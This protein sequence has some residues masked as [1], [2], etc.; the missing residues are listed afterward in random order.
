[1]L[2]SESMPTPAPLKPQLHT[3]PVI[4]LALLC[5]RCVALRGV[6]TE[7]AAAGGVHRRC[8]G[9]RLTET[10]ALRGAGMTAVGWGITMWSLA[11]I[12]WERR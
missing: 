8:Q 4:A 9:R 11:R 5:L 10:G 3:L 6:W 7:A 2:A 1:M 12:N